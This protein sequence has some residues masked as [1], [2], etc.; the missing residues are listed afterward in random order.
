[1]K[2]QTASQDGGQDPQ[3]EVVIIGAG[4]AGI[5]QLYRLVQ[6]GVNTTVLEGAG[7]LGGTW[8]HNRYPGCRFDSDLQW[9]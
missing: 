2:N 5:Y 4:V 9:S 6:L 7:G 3:Y 8:Y 1:M